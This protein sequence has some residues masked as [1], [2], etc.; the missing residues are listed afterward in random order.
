MAALTVKFHA[1]AFSQQC[2]SL[3]HK[4]HRALL[5]F[6]ILSCV[7]Y[8]TVAATPTKTDRHNVK[9]HS[10][11]ASTR[12]SFSISRMCQA[13][14]HKFQSSCMIRKRYREYCLAAPSRPEACSPTLTNNLGNFSNPTHFQTAH[15]HDATRR[16]T[17]RAMASL[18]RCPRSD[19]GDSR[20]PLQMWKAIVNDLGAGCPPSL[21][22]AFLGL[23]PS[24]TMRSEFEQV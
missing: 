24:D 1:G 12:R 10:Y 22:L 17:C 2:R 9:G 18:H 16:R 8:A 15:C 21:P 19:P 23:E 11:L 6:P 3:E 7:H 4:F 5:S 20:S 13:P 14:C